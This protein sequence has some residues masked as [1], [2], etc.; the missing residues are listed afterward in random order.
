MESAE[1]F[2]DKKKTQQRLPEPALVLG[3]DPEQQQ[4]YK[5]L[6]YDPMFD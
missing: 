6:L 2:I 1:S 4:Q 3:D 5:E